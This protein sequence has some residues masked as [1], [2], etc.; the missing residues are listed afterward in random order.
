M[1]KFTLMLF[2]LSF[3]V[4]FAQNEIS[5]KVSDSSGTGLSGVNVKE[6]GTTTG[7]STDFDGNYKIKVSENAVLVFSSVGFERVEKNASE[8]SVINVTL[9]DDGGSKLDDVV[10]VGTR[11]APRSNTTSALPVDVLT[12]KD[13]NSTGQATFD[14]A[15]QYKIPSFNT[16]QTPVND[17]TS[18]LDPYE[19]R[20]MGPSRTLVLINGKRKN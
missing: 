6:K 20:N 2:L 19:I 4:L 12:A 7:S 14:K 13:L 5:G 8:G 10:V 1:K 16:V 11:T 17:A 15:L 18:L 3:S 9:N